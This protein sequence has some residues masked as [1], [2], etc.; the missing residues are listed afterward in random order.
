MPQHQLDWLLRKPSVLYELLFPESF[1]RGKQGGSKR[2]AKSL[3]NALADF[4]A[5]VHAMQ[6]PGD[7]DELVISKLPMIL[8]QWQAML[9]EEGA[10]EILKSW[11]QKHPAVARHLS[12]N[13]RASQAER[14]DSR[15]LNIEKAWDGIHF[16]LT[17][18]RDP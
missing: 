2:R 11:A 8:R 17:G 5:F 12:G 15:S 16:V 6:N 1:E 9:G 14:D 3:G 10:Q 4:Q 18:T 13:P 7:N